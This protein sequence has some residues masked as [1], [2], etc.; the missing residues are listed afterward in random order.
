MMKDTFH[1]Q[2]GA[3]W[4]NLADGRILLIA[5]FADDGQ[6]DKFEQH[7]P[8][9]ISLPHPIHEANH[10]ISE[11]AAH[12]LATHPLLFAEHAEHADR[13]LAASKCTVHDICKRMAKHN[14]KFRLF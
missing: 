14:P 8:G 7:V 4:E 5:N 3:H 6:Q 10:P 9:R 12:H 11:E 2:A 1:P 13:K